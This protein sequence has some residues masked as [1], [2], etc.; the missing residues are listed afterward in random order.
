QRAA[1]LAHEPGLADARLAFDQY[2]SPPVG[3]DGT[4]D[5]G[6]FVRTTNELVVGYLQPRGQRDPRGE[7]IQRRASGRG[8]F[9]SGFLAQDRAFELAQPGARFNSE[10]AD[11]HGAHFLK[12]SQRIGLTS[13]AIEREQQQ[14]PASLSQW[15]FA[16]EY[17]EV[18]DNGR[19]LTARK[20]RV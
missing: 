1:R 20:P 6:Q 9:Q 18:G 14:L 13:A 19:V 3:R 12:A 4:G 15:V 8:P 7:R 16:H 2:K 10:L 17:L 11:Q 5:R